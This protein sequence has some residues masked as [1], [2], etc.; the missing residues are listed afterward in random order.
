VGLAVIANDELCANAFAASKCNS[1]KHSETPKS[2][3]FILYHLGLLS[4]AAHS[5]QRLTNSSSIHPRLQRWI[6][7]TIASSRKRSATERRALGPRS[8]QQQ[9]PI[10]GVAVVSWGRQILRACRWQIAY[11]RKISRER[12]EPSSRYRRP[13]LSELVQTNGYGLSHICNSEGTITGHC[14]VTT[15]DESIR[16][17][18]Q[19]PRKRIE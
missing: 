18:Q 19:G 8:L 11:R 13:A 15:T 4:G 14:C 7:A 10:S 16:W 3:F 2:F 9:H 6:T 17:F 12:V 1:V 5:A